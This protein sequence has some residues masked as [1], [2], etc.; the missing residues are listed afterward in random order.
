ML[1]VNREMAEVSGFESALHWAGRS[2][3]A[4]AGPKSDRGTL[5]DLVLAAR[6]HTAHSCTCVLYK[7]CGEPFYGLIVTWPLADERVRVW[8]EAGTKECLI[9]VADVT[10][11]VLK[12]VG[13]YTLG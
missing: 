9:G 13:R 4:L 5:K 11:R 2:V 12:T 7:R 1:A 3:L 10:Q 6:A 8:G